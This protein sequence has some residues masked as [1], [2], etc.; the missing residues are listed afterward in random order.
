MWLGNFAKHT[1]AHGV[2]KNKQKMQQKRST[3]NDNTTGNPFL[4]TASRGVFGGD[5]EKDQFCDILSNFL[6]NFELVNLH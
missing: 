6:W 1:V 2:Q 3:V 5:K 4:L